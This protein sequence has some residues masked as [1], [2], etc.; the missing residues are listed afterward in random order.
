M[1]VR[2]LLAAATLSAAA[3]L[4]A[5]PLPTEARPKAAIHAPR[6]GPVHLAYL[7]NAGW[8]IDDGKTVVLVDPYLT[9]FYFAAHPPKEDDPIVNPDT[10]GIDAHIKRADY[11]LI[12]HGHIDHL[13]DAPYIATK[14]GATIIC[15]ASAAVIARAR[16][17]PEKQIIIVK[18]GE[19]YDF[20][21]FSLRVIPSLHSP[22][23][24][25][26][27]NA[28][29]LAG[30]TPPDAKMPLHESDYREGGTLMYLLRLNGH[31]VLIA[32]GMNYIEREIEGLRPDIALVGSNASHKESYDY[33]GRYMRATGRPPIVL[34]TH[35]D[36]LDTLTHEQA[37]KNAEAFAAEV[38]A[39]SP[40]TKV[41]IPD[42][43]KTM[44][45]N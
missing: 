7:G 45:F 29:I 40:G 6:R 39:V 1:I 35:W 43:F 14:T 9:G 33:A 32:G 19:D 2:F 28:H 34:P 25:K 26:H 10:A 24:G 3:A 13:L 20:P 42:Y 16:G 5:L 11:I 18:G 37:V 38:K 4:S 12:T 23:W 17:V 27:Y 15:T 22:L 31:Q 21:G 30:S 44:T 41:I 8:Q 36:S